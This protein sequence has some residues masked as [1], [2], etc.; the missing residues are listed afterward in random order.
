MDEQSAAVRISH[1]NQ[2]NQPEIKDKK[3]QD[4]IGPKNSSSPGS[5]HCAALLPTSSNKSSGAASPNGFVPPSPEL[6]RRMSARSM[7][8]LSDKEQSFVLNT[9]LEQSSRVDPEHSVTNENSMKEPV[10]NGIQQLNS[11]LQEASRAEAC[12]MAIFEICQEQPVKTAIGMSH[13]ILQESRNQ[14]A[15][16]I[17]SES[18]ETVEPLLHAVGRSSGRY[19]GISASERY[20]GISTSGIPALENS[21]G[22]AKRKTLLPLPHLTSK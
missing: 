21:L 7:C 3:Y 2:N 18:I 17:L 4:N 5:Q 14:S 15:G 13:N 8:Y 6:K 12:H 16:A 1:I 9:I 10:T 20:E 11:V 19:E 22:P